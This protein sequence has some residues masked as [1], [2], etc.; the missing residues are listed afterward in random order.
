MPLG[1]LL[2]PAPPE[3]SPVAPPAATPAP[4]DDTSRETAVVCACEHAVANE[5]NEAALQRLRAVEWFECACENLLR[6]FADDVL[7]RELA[8]APADI[9]KLAQQALA[10]FADEEPLGVA[11]ALTEAR[12]LDL[13]L[14]VNG[15]ATLESG[16]VAVEVGDGRLLSSLRLRVDSVIADVLAEAALT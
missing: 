4:I 7:A 8:L 11:V 12:G 13:A 9:A 15:D 3:P 6:R 10:A 16:D 5:A 1:V 14:P 2:R